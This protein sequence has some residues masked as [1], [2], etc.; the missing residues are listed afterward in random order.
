MMCSPPVAQHRNVLG[1]SMQQAPRKFV[2]WHVRR[3]T[4]VLRESSALRADGGGRC[5][6]DERT[7]SNS[8]DVLGIRCSVETRNRWRSS[9]KVR[10]LMATRGPL[11]CLESWIL[12]SVAPICH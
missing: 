2:F 1:C 11:E 7:E 10:Q 8:G 6:R 4:V 5:G 12:D 9:P 3:I